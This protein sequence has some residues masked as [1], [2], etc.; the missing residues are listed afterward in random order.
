MKDLA[1]LG[2][3]VRDASEAGS[4]EKRSE[5]R[6]KSTGA[7]VAWFRS[8]ARASDGEQVTGVTTQFVRRKELTGEQIAAVEAWLR[9]QVLAAI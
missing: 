4:G 7:F 8:S 6:I 1:S 9:E 2:L 3:Q 5:V